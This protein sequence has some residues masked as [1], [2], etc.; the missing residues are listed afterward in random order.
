M[1]EYTTITTNLNADKPL[2][3][4]S[5]NA[6]WHP[7]DK[8]R[9]FKPKSVFIAMSFDDPDRITV[10]AD[11]SYKNPHQLIYLPEKG[12]ISWPINIDTCGTIISEIFD[13]P[14]FKTLISAIIDEHLDPDFEP[15]EIDRKI[16]TINV[17]STKCTLSLMTNGV[18]I[19]SAEQYIFQTL[20]MEKKWHDFT[21]SQAVNHVLCRIASSNC[22]YTFLEEA[23]M[24]GGDEVDH[25]V[26]A[27][28]FVMLKRLVTY[29]QQRKL[30][31]IPQELLSSLIADLDIVEYQNQ[32]D[33]SEE[34]IHRFNNIF[35]NQ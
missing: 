8:S 5:Q 26:A 33:T 31:K 11:Y 18:S 9:Q 10:K 12:F 27:I 13:S 20:K 16:G 2:Y 23:E 29:L 17:C 1:I 7:T 15:E 6:Q 30:N 22:T 25:Q 24:P 32:E 35:R 21:F 19:T 14:L 34:I 3:M 4:A 28:E